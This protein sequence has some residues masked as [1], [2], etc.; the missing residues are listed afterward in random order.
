MSYQARPLLPVLKWLS[1]GAVV[2]FFAGWVTAWLVHP[3]PN[4][5]R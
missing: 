1:Q 4:A 3:W 2:A 5:A